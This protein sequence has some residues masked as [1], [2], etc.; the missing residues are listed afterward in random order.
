MAGEAPQ[1]YERARTPKGG[2]AAQSA[3]KHNHRLAQRT[4]DGNLATILDF[5]IKF[6]FL[7]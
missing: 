2:R 1:I 6:S 5:Y 4:I 7:P 3:R